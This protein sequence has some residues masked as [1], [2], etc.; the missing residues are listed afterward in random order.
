M[1][2]T[3]SIRY[4]P[5]WEEIHWECR[6]VLPK[7]TK[8]TVCYFLSCVENSRQAH[9]TWKLSRLALIH[10]AHTPE[11]SCSR[12]DA[13]H[14]RGVYCEPHTRHARSSVYTVQFS[15]R[16][17]SRLRF[18]DVTNCPLPLPD[19]MILLPE[20]CGN[21]SF[22]SHVSG[23]RDDKLRLRP[24]LTN[25][26]LDP[27]PNV[28]LPGVSPPQNESVYRKILMVPSKSS[29]P[30]AIQILRKSMGNL[31]RS[32]VYLYNVL[33]KTTIFLVN[34]KSPPDKME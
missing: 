16:A 28:S 18:S 22:L 17:I 3:K 26:G 14:L 27:F 30:E 15:N 6:C 8:S 20:W 7:C 9:R 21:G 19:W 33:I 13:L 24:S 31:K 2:A 23:S 29:F 25:C 1:D 12:S 11:F 4:L 10:I 32:I 5:R 34:K